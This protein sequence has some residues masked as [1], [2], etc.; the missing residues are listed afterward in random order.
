MAQPSTLC[1]LCP[2]NSVPAE[3]WDPAE[4][5]LY[6]HEYLGLY[7]DFAFRFERDADWEESFGRIALNYMTWSLECVEDAQ[8]ALRARFAKPS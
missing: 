8:T 3:D 1:A 2:A 5:L 6:A 4:L 7:C